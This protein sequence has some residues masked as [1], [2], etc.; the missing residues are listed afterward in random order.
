MHIK[1]LSYHV[2]IHVCGCCF[3][4][5]AHVSTSTIYDDVITLFQPSHHDVILFVMM[6]FCSVMMSS[7]CS[8]SSLTPFRADISKSDEESAL[9]RVLQK[10]AK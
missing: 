4:C 8:F 1:S 5:L 7:H 9:N 3:L 6:S 10:T 2:R